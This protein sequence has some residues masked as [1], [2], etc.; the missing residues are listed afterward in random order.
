MIANVY[1]GKEISRWYILR[2][3]K[4]YFGIKNM[5]FNRNIIIAPETEN[6]CVSVFN[7]RIRL[8]I[9]DDDPEKKTTRMFQDFISTTFRNKTIGIECTD[10]DNFINNISDVEIINLN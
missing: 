10:C 6:Y 4:R 3:I 9:S 1:V 2:S 5:R 8:K 7:K